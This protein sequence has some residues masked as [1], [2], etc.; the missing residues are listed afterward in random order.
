MLEEEGLSPEQVDLLA[1]CVIE[2]NRKSTKRRKKKAKFAREI[3]LFYTSKSYYLF[4]IT[5]IIL[6]WV[7]I[8]LFPELNIMNCAQGHHWMTH[9]TFGMYLILTFIFDLVFCSQYGEKE[10]LK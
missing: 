6:Y 4:H 7:I 9:L 10:N 8:A 1:K 5:E 2:N 3:T